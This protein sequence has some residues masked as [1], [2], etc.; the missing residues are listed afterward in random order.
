MEGAIADDF[1][2]HA[3]DVG[4]PEGAIV[5]GLLLGG[6][7]GRGEAVGLG[8]DHERVHGFHVPVALHEFDGEPVEQ[9]GMEGGWPLLPKLKTVETAGGAE[10]AGPHMVHGHTGG[11]GIVFTGDPAGERE[12]TAGAGGGV[13]GADGSAAFAGSLRSLVA[14]SRRAAAAAFLFRENS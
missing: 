7:G 10:V 1:G 13:L 3:A 6:G 5:V 8:G 9:F 11:E 12:A 4:A 2:F 14:A